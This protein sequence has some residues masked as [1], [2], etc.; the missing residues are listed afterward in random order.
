MGPVKVS[1]R[2]SKLSVA[3][4]G[5]KITT[6]LEEDDEYLEALIA[7]IEAQDEEEEDAFQIPSLPP[8][9]SP[10]NGTGKIPKDLN[11]VNSTL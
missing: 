2:F 5:K 6:E 3:K 7:Q 4:K 1:P 11:V 8:Y 9:L 10:L